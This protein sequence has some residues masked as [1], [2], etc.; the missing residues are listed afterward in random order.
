MALK[1]ISVI[2]ITVLAVISL[3]LYF[4]K[5]SNFNDDSNISQPYKK[6]KAGGVKEAIYEWFDQRAYPGQSINIKHLTDAYEKFK[7]DQ[8]T[9]KTFSTTSWEAIG[10]KNFGGRTLFLAFNPINNN[11]LYAGS[12]SGGLWRSYTGGTGVNAWHYIPTGFP[13]LGVSSIVVSHADTN[14]IYIGTGEVYNYQNTGT[15]F[16]VRTTRG[17]YGIGI[18]K[19]TDN[20]ISWTKSLDWSYDELK[21]VQD[22]VI[23][24]L[25]SNTLWAATTEG[26]YVT[27]DA[28][29]NWILKHPVLMA[30]DIE[31][32][33]A[34]TSMIFVS[35][36][37]FVTPGHGIY[38]STDGGNNFTKLTIGLPPVYSGKTLIDI[39]PV[40]TNI[41]Y[42][43]IADSLSGIGLYASNDYGNTWILKNDTNVAKYQGWY[44]HDVVINPVDTNI[45]I[46]GGIDSWKSTNGGSSLIQKSLWYLWDFSATPIGGPEGPPNYVHADIHHIIYRPGTNNQVYFA[47]DGGV[48]RSMDNGESFE[49]CNGMYQTQQFYAN[50]SNSSMDSLFAI[51]GMQ[52]NATAVYEGNLSWRRVIGGDGLSTAIDPTNDNRVYASYQYLNVA[53][54]NN[55]AQTFNFLPIPAGN[56]TNT[57]FAGPYELCEAGPNILYAGRIDFYKSIDYGNSWINYLAIDGNP[58]N[59]IAVSPTDCDLVYAGTTP[60]YFPPAGV[61]KS[62]DGGLNWLDVSSTLPDRYPMDI[63]INPIDNN[64]VY[65]V[66]SGFGTDHLYK[67]TNGGQTWNAITGL[68]DVPTN[69]IVLDPLFPDVIYV[70]NDFGVYYS[71]DAG[72]N[73]Q[74]YNDGLQ[75]ATLVMHL[76][77]S[78]SNRKLRLASH[79]KGI[80]QRELIDPTAVSDNGLNSISQIFIYP[81]PASEFVKISLYLNTPSNTILEL[82]DMNGKLINI[83]EI[84]QSNK[85]W[86]HFNFNIKEL[87]SGVYFLRFNYNGQIRTKKIIKS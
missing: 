34:D 72:L 29:N 74:S 76:S 23:N 55:K 28:G 39:H 52:D 68:P 46:T 5:D 10:P 35:C 47:T 37:N 42:A 38:K 22:I 11:T 21:G 86:N 15:G 82:F 56:S 80:Y 16:S 81:N 44:S 71:T 85:G 54:S 24:P 48:F 78:H 83:K 40:H 75:D 49:G 73:W 32:N 84:N 77:I 3:F 70:G 27:Y 41:L 1:R 57:N 53:R 58:I 30:V 13:V 12:A 26:T 20:G 69:T 67:T 6:K 65:V 36:G 9:L 79:G 61:F 62:T 66:F 17:T 43:S 19:S 2:I 8:A 4:T 18:L 64:I 14:T 31:I 50:F 7:S 60:R 33:P 59:T 45:I 87:K 25:N 63:A 51:G